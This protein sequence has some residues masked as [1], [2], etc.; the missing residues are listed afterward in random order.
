M[1]H[2]LTQVVA[3]GGSMALPPPVVSGAPNGHNLNVSQA[4]GPTGSQPTTQPTGNFIGGTLKL[5]GRLLVAVASQVDPVKQ[6]EEERKKNDIELAK[7]RDVVSTLNI[8]S[9]LKQLLDTELVS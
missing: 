3:N 1:S 6:I 8:P 5:L 7:A 4:A 2:N 9:E